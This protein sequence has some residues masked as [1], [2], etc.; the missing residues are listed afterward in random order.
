MTVDGTHT[1]AATGMGR[2]DLYVAMSRGADVGLAYPGLAPCSPPDQR[3][4][5]MARWPISAAV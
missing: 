4:A 5:R 3:S 2:E 1:I